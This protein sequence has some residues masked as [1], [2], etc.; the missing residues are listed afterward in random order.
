MNNSDISKLL[1]MLSK[2]DK[3]DLQNGLSQASR[4]LSQEDKAKLEG[5]LKNMNR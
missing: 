3:K 1:S 4:I 5:M 2:M